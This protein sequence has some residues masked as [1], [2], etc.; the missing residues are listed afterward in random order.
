MVGPPLFYA[1]IYPSFYRSLNAI[2]PSG[3]KMSVLIQLSVKLGLVPIHGRLVS[4]GWNLEW[5]WGVPCGS[6][7]FTS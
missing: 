4:V 3:P 6:K 5:S 2:N 7:N 1:Q